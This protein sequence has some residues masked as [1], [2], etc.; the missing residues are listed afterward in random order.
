MKKYKRMEYG[1][2]NVEEKREERMERR[3]KENTEV[4]N[5]QRNVEEKRDKERE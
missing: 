1:Q 5:R 3:M 4:E 2:R